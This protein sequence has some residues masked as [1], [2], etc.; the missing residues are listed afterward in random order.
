MIYL[1]CGDCLELMSEIP[2]HS[3]DLILCDL[4][5]GTTGCKWDIVIPFE[6]LWEQYNRIMKPN[7]TVALFGSEPFAAMLKVSNL[8]MYKY[9]WVWEKNNGGN[10]QLVNEQP[11]KVHETISVFYN[12]TTSMVFADIINENMKRLELPYDAVSSLIMSKNGY[13][14]GWL[15]NKLSG[16]QLPTREQWAKLCDL[17]GIEDEYDK[18]YSQVIKHTYNMELSDVNVVCSNKG[19]GG[20]L[21]HMASE[22]KRDS[23]VQTKSGY[24]KSV[25]RFKRESGLHPTQ[26]P[27]ALLEF[28]IKTYTNEGGVVLDNCMGSGSTGVACVNTNRFFIGIEKDANYFELAKNRIMDAKRK[29]F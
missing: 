29:L 13:R 4:P 26:K 3:V 9:D 21:N 11:L 14:T 19:K 5:Y 23:Y 16:K 1:K 12:N 22:K 10:F 2:D 25:I 6:P 8:K 15:S 17:F 27:V 18:L 20:T 7:G 24:P 28:L